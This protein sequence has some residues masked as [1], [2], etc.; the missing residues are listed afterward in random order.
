MPAAAAEPPTETAME[1]AIDR[2]RAR[3]GGGG[4]HGERRSVDHHV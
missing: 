3:I 4:D 2:Y 1:R